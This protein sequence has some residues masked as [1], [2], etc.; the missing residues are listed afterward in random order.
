MT[1]FAFQLDV[2]AVQIGFDLR[3]NG[4]SVLS[5]TTHRRKTL[6]ARVD[7]FMVPDDNR[8]QASVYPVPIDPSDKERPSFQVRALATPD[9][10]MKDDVDI[11][12][13]AAHSEEAVRMA[14]EGRTEVLDSRT[15]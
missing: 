15:R 3:V 10:E 1:I 7:G 5:G 11:V 12:V 9:G 6:S 4:F 14:P 2:A 8:I 13:I